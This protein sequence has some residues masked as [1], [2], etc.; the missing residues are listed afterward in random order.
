MSCDLPLLKC[1]E[2]SDLKMKDI[3]MT[4]SQYSMLL[5]DLSTEM[6]VVSLM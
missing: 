4:G 5:G 2:T 3:P 6:L 1:K